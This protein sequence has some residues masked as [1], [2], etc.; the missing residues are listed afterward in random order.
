MLLGLIGLIKGMGEDSTH[1]ATGCVLI[2]LSVLFFWI[3]SKSRYELILMT[4]SGI[5]SAMSSRDKKKMFALRDA[6]NTAFSG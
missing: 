6:I 4:H 2:V 5:I 3:G 1:L